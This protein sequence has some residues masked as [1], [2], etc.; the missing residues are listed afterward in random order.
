MQLWL[1]GTPG[2]AGLC[3]EA[4]DAEKRERAAAGGT[5]AREAFP[6]GTGLLQPLH[7]LLLPLRVHVGL[8]V[9]SVPTQQLPTADRS[10]AAPSRTGPR[11]PALWLLSR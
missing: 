3:P 10:P 7:L 9:P 8:Q 1:P 5:V 6:G 11:L 4:D 2:A